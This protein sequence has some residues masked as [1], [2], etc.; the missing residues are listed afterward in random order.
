[1]LPP[2][3]PL[4]MPHPIVKAPTW[5]PLGMLQD[6]LAPPGGIIIE[7]LAVWRP[8]SKVLLH[9]EFITLAPHGLE[10]LEFLAAT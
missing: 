7:F 4:G 9:V 2:W 3:R 8:E 1:M 10:P 6:T 5:R